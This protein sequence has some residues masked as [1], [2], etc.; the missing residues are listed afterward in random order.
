MVLLEVVLSTALFAMA[1]LGVLAGLN[2]CFRSLGKMRL[3]SQAADLA[4][5]KVSEVHIGI[6]PLEDDGPNEYE[7]DESL[8][9]WTWEIVTEEVELDA[10]LELEMDG[11]QLLQVQV[12][13]TNVPS[14]YKYSTRFLMPE[15]PETESVEDQP[16]DIAGGTA[17]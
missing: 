11:P 12:V 2:S 13:V 1:A 15:P 9:D 7:D 5:S 6:V 4:I 16:E 10:E 8:A 3:E 17:P 14:G